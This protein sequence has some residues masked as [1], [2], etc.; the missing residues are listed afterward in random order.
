MSSDTHSTPTPPILPTSINWVCVSGIRISYV[1]RTADEL[2]ASG[3]VQRDE[4][5]PL[6]NKKTRSDNVR[7]FSTR[8]GKFNVHI[9]A[10][11]AMSR[12]GK[13]KQFLGGLLADTR[14]SLVR[15][16]GQS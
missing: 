5:P 12:D 10:D 7:V 14:L 1:R 9:C 4:L 11:V 6:R 16:E 15:G 8:D 3:L 2:I 13:F